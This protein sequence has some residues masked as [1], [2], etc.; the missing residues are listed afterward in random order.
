MLYRVPEETRRGMEHVASMIASMRI[1]L[2]SEQPVD[3]LLERLGFFG[4]E[5]VK[6]DVIKQKLEKVKLDGRDW[7]RLSSIGQG[8]MTKRRDR[9]KC[10]C[11][12]ASTPIPNY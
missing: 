8:K 11:C 2:Q 9:S 1:L 4:S 3:K 7:P 6:Y 5:Q 10:K 12:F